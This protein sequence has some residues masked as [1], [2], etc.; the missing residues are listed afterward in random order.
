MKARLGGLRAHMLNILVVGLLGASVFFTVEVERRRE[1]LQATQEGDFQAGDQV[2]VV[3]AVDGDE[4]SVTDGQGRR[5]LVR[6]VGLRAFAPAISDPV[7]GTHGQ[8]AFNHLSRLIG[9]KVTVFP[10]DPA[11]DARQ[12]LLAHLETTLSDP[13]VDVAREMIEQGLG[14]AYTEYAHAR[15]VDYLAAEVEAAR[16]RR[17]VWADDALVERIQAQKQAWS[18]RRS[19]RQ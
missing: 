1:A 18:D 15:E 14:V 4:V 16:A 13:P 3:A 2:L 17:G 5:T 8:R 6:L 11:R 10:G 7:V 19:R 9:Q 12:R